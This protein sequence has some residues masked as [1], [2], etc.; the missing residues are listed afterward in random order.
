MTAYYNEI[1]P[2]AADWLGN[3]IAAGHI[4][5]GVVDTRS[6]EDVSP[7]DL[8]EFTQCHFF[9][10]IGGWPLALRLA[11]WPD[12]RPVWTGSCPCQPFSAAGKGGGHADERHLWPAWHHLIRHYRPSVVLG[13]Q[14][15]AAIAHGWLD[16]VQSDLE[17]EGYSLRATC[18]PACA[19][20]APQ[21]RQRL[22]WVADDDGAGRGLERRGGLLDGQR[23]AQ[24]GDADGRSEVCEL[25]N[26]GSKG[27][28]EQRKLPGVSRSA[29]GTGAGQAIERAD[30]SATGR[31]ADADGGIR[32]AGEQAQRGVCGGPGR[33]EPAGVLD[34]WADLEWIECSDG[35]ARPTQP[36]LCPLAHGIPN[37]VGRLRAYGNAIVPQ[38]AAAFIRAYVDLDIL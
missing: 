8:R 34:A 31:L 36:G 23:P 20:G 28:Q 21:R 2:Y 14:V 17:G 15:E 12:K 13:E 24:W 33:T 27:L 6:I 7:A 26:A 9:A 25:G 4:A 10:G 37:R 38:V 29:S 11:G 16:L 35:K 30:A 22:W 1:D 19:V 5:D 18:I 3:L 32:R